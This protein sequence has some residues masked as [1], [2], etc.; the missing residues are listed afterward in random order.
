MEGRKWSFR[1]LTESDLVFNMLKIKSHPLPQL[2]TCIF[3]CSFKCLL[4][5]P[6]LILS[7]VRKHYMI[8]GSCEQQVLMKILTPLQSK[9]ISLLF[10]FYIN[11]QIEIWPLIMIWSLLILCVCNSGSLFF[12]FHLCSYI[13]IWLFNSLFYYIFTITLV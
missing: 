2:W 10:F 6:I 5:Y 7:V 3:F 12:F 4:R 8:F 11:F 13:S 9:Y 1:W